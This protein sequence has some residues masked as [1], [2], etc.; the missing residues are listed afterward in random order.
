LTGIVEILCGS[1][2]G[3]VLF[4]AVAGGGSAGMT[5]ATGAVWFNG[6]KAKALLKPCATSFVADG[7]LA[8]G[9]VDPHAAYALLNAPSPGAPF[10]IAMMA[11]R[12][13]A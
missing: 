13:L 12:W 8:D 3:I 5:P 2:F 11:R 4:E 9:E 6:E 7:A 10:S 1:L